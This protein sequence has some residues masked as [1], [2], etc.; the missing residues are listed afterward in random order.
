MSYLSE[1]RQE[2]RDRRRCEIVDAAEALYAETGWDSVT[3]DQVARRAR[4]SR[5]LLY[6]YFRDKGD[7]HFALVE[8][9]LE[10][11]IRRIGRARDGQ[12]NGLEELDA[13]G[14]AY[15]GFSRE[16]P[17]YFDACARFEAHQFD[18]GERPANERA[19]LATGH[20]VH[21]LIVESINRGVADGS[22]RADLD[23]PFATALALWSFS[24]GLIQIAFTKSAQ[25]ERE[26]VS[27]QALVERSFE[28]IRRSLR[29]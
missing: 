18:Q 17:H 21:A 25:L 2:E 8:R 11:L 22:I 14:R 26:G 28:L 27:P 9:A 13:I 19:C 29:R 12:P 6:V 5:A 1:R 16:L 15:L 20:R 7:L 4:L 24:H 10:E 3:M 23:N